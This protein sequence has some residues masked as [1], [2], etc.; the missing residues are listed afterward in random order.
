MRSIFLHLFAFLFI[1]PSALCQEGIRVTP[2]DSAY[3]LPEIRISANRYSLSY[4]YVAARISRID[5][6]QVEST[7]GQSLDQVLQR[8][9]GVFLRQYGTGL[10]SLSLRGGGSSHSIITIDGMPLYDPQLGQVDL[11]LVPSMLLESISIMH[12]QASSL[13]GANGLSGVIDIESRNYQSSPAYGSLMAAMGAYG[14]RQ[15][16]GS[17]GFKK[18]NLRGLIAARYGAEEGDFSYE[19]P[20][21][22]PVETVKRQGAD[23]SYSSFL[24]K[25][26]WV[27]LRSHSSVSVWTNQFERGIPGPINLTFRDERQWDRLVRLNLQHVRLAPGGSFSFR[28]GIQRMSLRYAN[29]FLDIDDTGRTH[30]FSLDTYYKHQL[31]P[32]NTFK[33][34]LDNAIRIARHPSLAKK[35]NEFQTSLYV[36]GEQNIGVLVLL[37]S[38]RLD[39]YELPRN[40]TITAFS[41]N[42]GV[43]INPAFLSQL[44]IKA[45]AGKSFRPP[46]FNDRFWQPGGNLDLKPEIGWGYEGGLMWN[47]PSQG[48]FPTWSSEVTVFR[49]HISDQ[50]TWLPSDNGYWSPINVR[51]VLLSGLE[52]SF[53]VEP[54]MGG[55]LN[56]RLELIYHLTDA[57]NQS[58]PTSASYNKPLRYSPRHLFKAML[59]A[60]KSFEKWALGMDVFTQLTSE[61][62]VTEDGSSS[63][64][65]YMN[66]DMRIH[67]SLATQ[68]ARLS[69]QVIMENVFDR[70]YEVIKGYL[71]PPRILRVEL[72][73]QWPGRRKITHQ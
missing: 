25:L 69:L 12:G 22:F 27:N 8:A 45:Q 59:G 32:Q 49:Q 4:K 42:V 7:G 65:S 57:R 47:G 35:A 46:T 39:R 16:D 50:I 37:P 70:D 55:N 60:N 71:M 33:V 53:R 1:I 19:D 18:N 9:G 58:D 62:F 48:D 28:T 26:D 38:L 73:I 52:S 43:N 61:R 40:K 31:S 56:T 29:P 36:S 20:S 14:E 5:P 67:A 6:Q 3:N 51:G 44:F 64:P 24:G 68:T 11:S 13:Y 72:G 21:L 17:L 10:S 34:G 2:S 66:A 63:L 41:P 30:S 23:R 15:I 54:T